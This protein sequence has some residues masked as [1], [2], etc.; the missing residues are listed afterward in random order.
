MKIRNDTQIPKVR[1][2]P[3]LKFTIEGLVRFY[4]ISIMAPGLFCVNDEF[5]M[6]VTDTEGTNVQNLEDL[7]EETFS[8]YGLHT[9]NSDNE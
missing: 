1:V 9:V 5:K 4:H 3:L 8:C 6:I 2:V 7:A